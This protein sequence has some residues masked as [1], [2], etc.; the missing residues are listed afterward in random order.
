[1]DSTSLQKQLI[2]QCLKVPLEIIRIIKDY[3]FMDVT[4]SNTKKN[5]DRLSYLI[6]TTKWCGKKRPQD[7]ENGITVFYIN[8]DVRSPQFQII[9]CKKCGDYVGHTKL[10]FEGQFDKVECLC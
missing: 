8:K 5:K 6:G 1:M 2:M 4:M 10:T 3:T 9:F 7:E